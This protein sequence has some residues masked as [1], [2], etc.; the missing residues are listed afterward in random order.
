MIPC[1]LCLLPAQFCDEITD[2]RDFES[3]KQIEGR[4]AL[5]TAANRVSK[6]IIVDVLCRQAEVLRDPR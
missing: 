3:H 1:D 5:W 4:H 2:A 6:Y